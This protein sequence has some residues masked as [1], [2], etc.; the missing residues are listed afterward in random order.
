MAA[1]CK[2]LEFSP[3]SQHEVR[4]S[5]PGHS[6]GDARR[7]TGADFIAP[8]GVLR[9][10]HVAAISYRVTL[11]NA[12]A[13]I[14]ISSEMAVNGQAAPANANDSRQTKKLF[15]AGH[16]IT[17]PGYA[18]DSRIVLC[19]ATGKSCLS[20]T[21]A[22]DHRLETQCTHAHKVSHSRRLRQDCFCNR[23]SA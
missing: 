15:Q 11:L 18:E 10:W 13:S 16:S 3:A 12:P 5:R 19:H 22:I 21:S 2:P 4:N 6:V 1:Q 7:K 9:Q 14:V 20:L 23:G 8:L 17:G